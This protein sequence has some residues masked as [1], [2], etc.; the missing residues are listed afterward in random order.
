MRQTLKE[1]VR[2]TLGSIVIVSDIFFTN[3]LPKTRSGK[4]MRRLIK[5]IISN[6][7]LGDYSTIEDESAIEELKAAAE[8]DEVHYFAL[9]FFFCAMFARYDA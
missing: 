1:L 7:S 5:A 6:K 8:E 2:K 9:I 3:K 4:I